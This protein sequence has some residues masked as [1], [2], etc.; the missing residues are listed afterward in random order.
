MDKKQVTLDTIANLC[1][2]RGFV[3]QSSEIYGGFPNVYD[4]GPLGSLLKNNIKALWIRENLEKRDDMYLIDGAVLMHPKAWEASGHV[5]SFTDPMIDCTQC[6]KRFRADQLKGWEMKKDNKTGEWSI[7]KKGETKCPSCGGKL[8]DDIRVFNLMMETYVG[9][10]KDKQ[11][12]AYLKPESCQNIYLDYEWVQECMRAKLPFG[13]AQIGKAFRNELTQGQFIFRLREFEQMD[14]QFFVAPKGADEWYKKWKDLRMDWYLKAL[15][16]SKANLRWRQHPDEERIFYA[17][18]AWDIDYQFPYGWKELEGVHDRSDYDLKAHA[19]ASGK[20]LSYF[21]A[22]HNEKLVPFIVETSVGLDRI[23][24]IVMFEFYTEEEVKDVNGKMDKRVVMKF[25]E[26]L[27]P[28]KA[29]VFPLMKKPELVKKAKELYAELKKKHGYVI[30]DEIGSIGKRYR[31]QD[32]IGT[33]KCYTIDFQTLED[34]TVTVRD[35][36]TMKQERIK[37][38]T[39]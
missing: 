35:R 25:P 28:I 7:V 23:F 30:Y 9:A 13:I 15:G 22:E 21:D 27:A 24:L 12:K 3:N 39:I 32:E 34:G 17:R 2:R 20:E 31:R 1:K 29:A 37:L 26:E 19:K 36:D 4:Y 8:M 16:I 6:K 11:S 14:V 38:E 10:V 33:P 5:D 18:D